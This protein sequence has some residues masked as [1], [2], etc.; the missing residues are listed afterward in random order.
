MELMPERGIEKTLYHNPTGE[1]G[2]GNYE[3]DQSMKMQSQKQF[4]NKVAAF[5]G[6]Y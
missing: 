4:S 2:P 3:L 5:A 1:L 6:T